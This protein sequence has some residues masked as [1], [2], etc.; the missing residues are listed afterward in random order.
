MIWP[1]ITYYIVVCTHLQ[2]ILWIWYARQD[3][4]NIIRYQ[5][6]KFSCWNMWQKNCIWIW[7]IRKIPKSLRLKSEYL[8]HIICRVQLKNFVFITSAF[9]E[10]QQKFDVNLCVSRSPQNVLQ[11]M[12]KFGSAF[13]HHGNAMD[14]HNVLMGA[15]KHL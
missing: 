10:I 13:L 15:T 4:I 2:Y 1:D 14:I 7:N 8:L 3:N 11:K 12:A 6:S 5:I 9:L